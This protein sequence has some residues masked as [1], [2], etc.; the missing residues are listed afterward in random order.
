MPDLT[1]LVY[2]LQ[3]QIAALHTELD[4]LK[5]RK[6]IQYISLDPGNTALDYR[7]DSLHVVVLCDTDTNNF[8]VNL[9]FLRDAKDTIF[10]FIKT[11][12]DNVLTV[13][14]KGG[15]LINGSATKELNDVNSSMAIYATTEWKI[16]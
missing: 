14:P 1:P 9:P 6:F 8:T 4:K 16:L 3:S 11:D 7:R 12:N 2:Q 5:R 10:H 15:E 13:S